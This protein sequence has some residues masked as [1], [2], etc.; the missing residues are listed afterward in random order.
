M[1]PKKVPFWLI[2]FKMFMVLLGISLLQRIDLFD[3]QISNS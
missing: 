1:Q 3:L 2:R